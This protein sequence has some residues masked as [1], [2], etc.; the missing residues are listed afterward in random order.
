MQPISQFGQALTLLC[1]VIFVGV[2][3]GLSMH[4]CN[5]LYAKH[6]F[7]CV[8]GKQCQED[9]G[10]AV[11]DKLRSE[12][13]ERGLRKQI[14]IN[15]SGCLGE[16]GNGPMVVVYP[17]GV[18]YCKVKASDCKDIVKEHLL[19]NRPIRRLFYVSGNGSTEDTAGT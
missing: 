6:V 12:V 7:V 11:L 14:R 17:D 5:Q 18:W 15:K 4:D 9:G 3:T 1:I 10:D 19:K 8:T 2:F 13:K 16:C